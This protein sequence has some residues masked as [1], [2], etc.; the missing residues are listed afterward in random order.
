VKIVAKIFL[1]SLDLENDCRLPILSDS[2]RQP[3]SQIRKIFR[4]SPIRDSILQNYT[5]QEKGKE[6]SL[7]L[8]CKTRWNNLEA[9]IER[10]IA[11]KECVD[12]GASHM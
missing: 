3:I 6:L 7:I 10:F 5:K 1:N 12:I 2:Y 8:D 4:K 11:L 9:V